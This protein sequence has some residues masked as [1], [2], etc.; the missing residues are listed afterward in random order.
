[1]VKQ[2]PN[3]RNCRPK[4]QVMLEGC[5]EN[6]VSCLSKYL[7][8]NENHIYIYIYIDQGFQAFL[9][10]VH[11][12][13]RNSSVVHI[14]QNV[15]NNNFSIFTIYIIPV[16]PFNYLIIRFIIKIFLFIYFEDVTFFFFSKVTTP[17]RCTWKFYAVHTVHHGA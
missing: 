12:I 4:C 16:I 13:F 15:E 10:L 2:L 14:S 1:M 7:E 11:Q 6:F 9:R 5:T 3:N 8:K 17:S